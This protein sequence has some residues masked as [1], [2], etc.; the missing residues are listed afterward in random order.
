MFKR[1]HY[2][3][4]GVVLFTVLVILSLPNRVA[5]QLKLGIGSLFIPLFGLAGTAHTLADK[6]QDSL[7]PRRALLRQIDELK[8][9]N[10]RLQLE[11]IQWDQVARE[12][13]QLRQAFGWLSNSP[14]KFKLGR[15]ILRDPTDW[16]RTLQIDLGQRDGIVTNMTVM[17]TEGLIG[18][19][20]HVAYSRAQVVLIGN[21]DC[22][23]AAFVEE[24]PSK[25][26]DGVITSSASSLDGNIV[27]LSY[28]EGNA[29]LRPGQR[30]VTSGLG[31]VY[32][33]GIPIGHV[34]DAS[35]V[36]FGM[37]TEARVKLAADLNHLDHVF[38]ICQ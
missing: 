22:S 34:L 7:V 21:P 5:E 13:E 18:R 1:P 17:T 25:V 30:V 24:S 10:Q 36:G 9:E 23:V 16:W 28:V 11:K 15:V 33:K 2:L 8:R 29:S 19:I 6:A 4:L 14:P 3:A 27:K 12:N 31:G 35:T 26:V 32:P 37:Y 38:V 20:H